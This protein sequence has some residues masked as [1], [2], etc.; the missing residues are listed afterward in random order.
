MT[1][2]KKALVTT[3]DPT[4]IQNPSQIPPAGSQFA[5]TSSQKLVDVYFGTLAGD[6]DAQPAAKELQGTGTDTGS[7]SNADYIY[8]QV[9]ALYGGVDLPDF[10]SP[11]GNTVKSVVF[12]SGSSQGGYGAF[13][14]EGQS[15]ADFDRIVVDS[16]A[17]TGNYSPGSGLITALARAA[18]KA[19]RLF[20]KYRGVSDLLDIVQTTDAR[21]KAAKPAALIEAL[22]MATQSSLALRSAL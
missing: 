9:S 19:H 7:L 22:K 1:A 11:S 21:Q 8:K 12:V 4:Q 20:P 10:Q 16:L 2:V 14:I 15:Q 3:V 17:V 13:H 6:I 18:F 5:G